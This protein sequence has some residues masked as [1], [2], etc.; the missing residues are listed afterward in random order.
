MI[1]ITAKPDLI[2]PLTQI[3]SITPVSTDLDS[4]KNSSE[5]LPGQKYQAL[6][7]ARLSNGN[8]RV[9]IANQWFQMQL[10]ENFQSGVK[11]EL[12]VTSRLP[13]LQFQIINGT[14]EQASDQPAT[15]SSTGKLISALLQDAHKQST[16]TSQNT[17]ISPSI[18]SESSINSTELPSLLQKAISQSGLFYESH[19]A[20]WINGEKTLQSLH[21]EPQNKMNS[22]VMAAMDQSVAR[23]VAASSNTMDVAVNNQIN[24]LVTQQ[25]S[26]LET[27]Q[28]VWRGEIWHNQP[29]EWEIYEQPEDH[30]Q[31][32][33]EQT[34]QWHTKLHLTMPNLGEITAKI[35]FGP[36][37]LTIKLDA[38]DR[39]TIDLL[40]NNQQPLASQIQAAGLNVQSVEIHQYEK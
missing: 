23:A 14:Q 2:T 8:A 24:T 6:V 16:P 36:H 33:H 31:N 3:K 15:I 29:M 38:I 12:L 34:V 27:G 17:Q 35:A 7:D 22:T 40:K 11:I 10:P 13:E 1:P 18:S 5:F 4:Q 21:Q 32:E 30:K 20:Q 37:G 9:L 25:L 39:N 26:T 28:V 19:Q